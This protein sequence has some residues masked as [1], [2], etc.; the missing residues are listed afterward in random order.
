MTVTVSQLKRK[1]AAVM[2]TV[3]PLRSQIRMPRRRPNQVGK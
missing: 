1:K 2:Q 3:V